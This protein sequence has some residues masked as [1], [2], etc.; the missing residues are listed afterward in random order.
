MSAIGVNAGGVN[1]GSL[2]GFVEDSLTL[3]VVPARPDGH[4][5]SSDGD[6]LHTPSSHTSWRH[7]RLW[8]S[9]P[10]VRIIR[11]RRRPLSRLCGLTL[12]SRVLKVRQSLVFARPTLRCAR[13]APHG[14]SALPTFGGFRGTA[15]LK[16]CRLRRVST[17]SAQPGNLAHAYLRFPCEFHVSPGASADRARDSVASFLDEKVYER[18]LAGV[19]RPLDSVSSIRFTRDRSVLHGSI[20]GFAGRKGDYAPRTPND[21]SVPFATSRPL[22]PRSPV[23]SQK[24]DPPLLLTSRRLAL[25][26]TS[27]R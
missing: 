11:P 24:R 5:L 1:H 22:G 9:A 2:A 23:S 4:I 3:S 21:R 15:P 17:R 27:Q 12:W 6:V 8:P 13:T 16:S 20:A 25:L 10:T 7:S 14:R 18:D 19:I 26:Y